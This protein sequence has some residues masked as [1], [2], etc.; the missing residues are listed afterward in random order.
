MKLKTIAAGALASALLL[1]GCAGG[2]GGEETG[3]A[4][5]PSDGASL[6]LAKP[7]GPISTEV[8][9]PFSGD[10]SAM[11]LGYA[12]AIFETVGIVNLLDPS[13]EPV[14]R[15]ASEI[16]WNDDY[17]VLELT[18][19]DGV[20][21]NDG[22]DFTA[23]D[24]AWNYQLYKDEPELDNAALGISDV[25]LDGDKVTITFENPMFV[26]TDK[27]LHK[28]ILPKHIWEDVED[29]A[30]FDNQNPVGTGPYELKQFTTQSV[31]LSARDDYWEG[32][33]AVPTL[34]YVSYNDNTALVNAL[35]TGEAD[36]AQAFI[37]NVESTYLS[38]DPEHN[39]FWAAP[40]MGIDAMYVN[41]T[42]KPFDDVNFRKA[43]NMV[44]DRQ[45][46][47]EIA[48]ENAAPPITSVTA[49][50]LPVGEAFVTD[51][52]QGE[53]L[54]VDVEAALK[55]LT[56]N[57]Y[58]QDSSGTLLDADGEAV[59]FT[60]SVP[61][62]WNDY[63]TGASLVADAVGELG[64]QVDLDTP[65]ADSWWENRSNGTFDAI[66]HWTDT[67]A[68]AY[69]HFSDM[70]DGRWLKPIGEPAD[71]NF[72]RYDNAEATEALSKYANASSDEDRQVALEEVE[73]IYVEQVPAMPIGTRPFFGAYN[74][75]NYVGW[76]DESNPYAPT[77]QTQVSAAL[78]LMNLEPV[79]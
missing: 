35:A 69:D 13:S 60:I 4:G 15:L 20:K 68:T 52:F 25:A 79:K 28:L 70:M 71:Y 72:G 63:V 58:T 39:F 7:D 11:R 44:I 50:P 23:E 54:V 53:E 9:N 56:D 55:L 74:T 2:S 29:K 1:T 26:R 78:V 41:T 24:I 49:L 73:R 31:E 51:E 33:P 48:R 46:H 6:T 37:P 3:D 12:N 64:V 8:N 14:P 36:W 61:Q 75:R 18:A 38:K 17:T 77:D 42:E 45:K 22:T 10:S 76:P 32:K 40:A 19:R 59:S 34:Y 27:V 62:G 21:W 67:G 57:G 5:A 65:D 47:S 66:F 30:T 16:E 43:V